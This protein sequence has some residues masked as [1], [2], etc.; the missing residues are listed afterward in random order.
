VL[1]QPSIGVLPALDRNL[2]QNIADVWRYR[3]KPPQFDQ[4]LLF[5]SVD[6]AGAIFAA[7]FL[8]EFAKQLCDRRQHRPSPLIPH[9]QEHLFHVG[10]KQKDRPKAASVKSGG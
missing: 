6:I 8:N 4:P 2:I 1:A 5:P 10:E 7:T 3:G 9:L